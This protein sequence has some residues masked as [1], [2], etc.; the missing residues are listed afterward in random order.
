MHLSEKQKLKKLQAQKS[1]LDNAN[2]KISH[3][4]SKMQ[5]MIKKEGVTINRDMASDFQDILSCSELA[6]AEGIFLQQ[7]VKASQKANMKGMRWH[8]T[9][10][11][12]A[13]SIYLT[14]PT[15]YETARDTGM[16]KLP[17]RRTLFDYSHAKSINDGIDQVVLDDLEERVKNVTK[18]RRYHVL[19]ADEMHVCQNLVFQKSSGKLIGYTNLHEVDKEVKIFE[20]HLDNPEKEFQELLVSKALVY[21]VKGVAIGTK[22]VIATYGVDSPSVEQMTTWTWQVIGALERSGIPI[23]A[24]ICDGFS[25]NRAFIRRHVPVTKLSSGVV[26]DS[27]NRAAGDRV[28][29]FISDFSHLIKTIRNC[30]L[31]SRCDKKKSRRNMMRR[32]KKISWDF[33]IKLYEL[34]KGKSLRKSFKLNAMNVYPDSYGRM[35]VKYAGQVCSD[36]VAQDL[37]DQG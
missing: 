8:P 27:V 7:Q 1:D 15:A 28:I 2:R 13:L 11:R 9:M 3:L 37:E 36:T 26:F 6:P 20:Q 10:I 24:F 19:M 4:Q 21:M 34:K 31:N 18:Q 16:V 5:K 25:V 32:G 12:F 30:S 23:I 29:Y 33:I 14:S 17:C 35:S 22:E